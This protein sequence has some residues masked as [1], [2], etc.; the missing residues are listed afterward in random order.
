MTRIRQVRFAVLAVSVASLLLGYGALGARE[1]QAA[2]A[3][4]DGSHDFDFNFG[5]WNTHIRRLAHPL[6]GSKQYIEMTGTVTVRKVWDG[7]AQLEEIEADGPNGHWQG[8][9][10]FLYNPVSHQWSQTFASSAS[11]QLNPGTVGSFKDGRGELYSQ[12]TFNGRSIL[13]RGIWSNITPDA[14]RYEEDYSDDGGKTWEAVF[15]ADLTRKQ[16]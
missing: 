12:D 1:L 15:M 5:V 14:H 13:I 6:A 16:P 4:H 8:M 10:L 11:G 7:R 3:A 2:E 9:T